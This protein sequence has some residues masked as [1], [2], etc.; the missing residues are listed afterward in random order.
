ME[1]S[2]A[3]G[4]VR[5]ELEG[6]AQ[7]SADAQLK[8]AQPRASD[9]ILTIPNVLSVLRLCSVPV[10]VWL[11]L[12]DHRNAAVIL[13][14]IAAWSDFFD[15]LIARRFDQVSELG[16][17]L[18]P[19]ADRVFIV[20]LAIALV[21]RGTLPWWLAL[22]IIGRDALLLVVFPFLE[23]RKVRIAVNF[24]GKTA[25]AALLFGLT[26]LALSETTLPGNG[27]G[28]FVGISFTIFGAVAY[29]VAAVMYA[30]EASVKLR[31]VDRESDGGASA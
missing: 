15:G 9:R 13:Y 18:D 4:K 14:G 31:A 19:L 16:K 2:R 5:V 30:K 28:E 1:G 11:F 6:D 21:G 23:R 10:F 8:E 27:I 20:A 3:S 22:T 17:L 25:T 29:W 24:T 26:W 12:T 7:L